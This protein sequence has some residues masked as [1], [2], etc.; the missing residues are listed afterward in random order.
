MLSG[1]SEVIEV[2]RP[3]I[4]GYL[5]GALANPVSVEMRLDNLE[6]SESGSSS[7][8]KIDPDQNVCIQQGRVLRL[9]LYA[10]RK[11][12]R[13]QVNP[14]L[15]K[16][17]GGP[18]LRQSLKSLISLLVLERGGLLLHASAVQYEGYSLLFAGPSGSGKSTIA[19]YF[20]REAMLN[21]DL[22]AVYPTA[23]GLVAHST[24]FNGTLELKTVSRRA[25][26]LKAFTL[27][28]SQENRIG[29]KSTK[30]SLRSWLSNIALPEG[31][32]ALEEKAFSIAFKCNEQIQFQ[33]LEFRDDPTETLPFL[34]ETVS[35]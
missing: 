16:Q 33:N 28:Q 10:D 32:P 31:I 23:H 2:L 29:T 20:P 12:A 27:T 9:T 18:I 6:C 25:K 17:L 26:V 5:S 21:D 35:S 30:E 34:V 1:G 13:L 3:E 24:P 22:I 15:S 19:S 4:D 11:G 7:T 14:T 8:T